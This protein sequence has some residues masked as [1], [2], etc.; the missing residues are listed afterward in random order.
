[1]E[2]GCQLYQGY[3]FARPMPVEDFEQLEQTETRKKEGT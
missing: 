3:Y 2:M 1:M